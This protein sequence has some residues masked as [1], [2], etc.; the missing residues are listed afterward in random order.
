[1]FYVDIDIPIYEGHD[2]EALKIVD[3]SKVDTL[4]TFGFQEDVARKA[5]KA[6]VIFSFLYVPAL[7]CD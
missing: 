1:M 5:L 2:S 4:I 6:S 3:Q 7:L